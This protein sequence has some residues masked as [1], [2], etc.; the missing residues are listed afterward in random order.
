MLCPECGTSNSSRSVACRHCGAPFSGNTEKSPWD[1]MIGSRSDH[2]VPSQEDQRAKNQS[3]ES[4]VRRPDASPRS[5]VRSRRPI[6]KKVVTPEMVKRP[7]IR[8]KSEHELTPPHR[9]QALRAAVPPPAVAMPPPVP[10]ASQLPTQEDRN[11]EPSL[12]AS[13]EA[14]TDRPGPAQPEDSSAESLA[15]VDPV[16]KLPKGHQSEEPEM[17]VSFQVAGI[18]QRMSVFFVDGLVG[19]VLLQGLISFGL[20]SLDG[21]HLGH[22]LS[23]DALANTFRD[24]HLIPL[25]FAGTVTSGLMYFAMSATVGRSLGEMAF[26]LQLIHRDSGERPDLQYVGKRCLGGILSFFAFLAGYFWVLVDPEFRTWHDQLS[27]TI[28]VKFRPG[29]SISDPSMTTGDLPRVR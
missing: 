16:L 12:V 2:H 21:S 11:T 6:P 17:I 7:V 5:P 29:T 25:I 14:P 9:V 22:L 3:L 8:P 26:G 24:G 18:R 19:L 4:K 23:L 10:A 13:D 1:K 20:V 28:L 15:S 27:R